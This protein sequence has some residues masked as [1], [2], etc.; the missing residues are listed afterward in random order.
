MNPKLQTS[1]KPQPDTD[2]R[3]QAEKDHA[4]G[5]GG[6]YAFDT[7]LGRIVRTEEAT[8]HA[9]VSRKHVQVREG[10]KAAAPAPATAAA[11]AG[12]AAATAG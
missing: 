11:P 1:A 10:Y 4:A 7:K 6:S 3:T 5:V 12:G 8:E 9:A 2:T